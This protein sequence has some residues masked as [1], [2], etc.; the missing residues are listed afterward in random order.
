MA[1]PW[2][3]RAS[4]GL[5]LWLTTLSCDPH[6]CLPVPLQPLAVH[7]G[8]GGGRHWQCQPRPPEGVLH[9]LQAVPNGGCAAPH[10][11]LQS[12]VSGRQSAWDPRHPEAA[13]M[14]LWE[15][16]LVQQDVQFFSVC[17]RWDALRWTWSSWCFLKENTV[18]QLA[19]T[20]LRFILHLV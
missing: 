15:C 1:F 11:V 7:P 10:G 17:S 3:W 19:S 20:F 8:D 16:S 5:C 14:L 9:Q 2:H 13:G 4:R 12:P 6:F 18:F